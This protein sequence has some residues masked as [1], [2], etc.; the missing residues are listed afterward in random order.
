MYYLLCVQNNTRMHRHPNAQHSVAVLRAQ[1]KLKTLCNNH[2]APKIQQQHATPGET[3]ITWSRWF[4]RNT[5]LCMHCLA[6]WVWNTC[7]RWT[8]TWH[9]DLCWIV[10]R[11]LIKISPWRTKKRCFVCVR[12]LVVGYDR[13]MHCIMC[14]LPGSGSCCN[15]MSTVGL[16]QRFWLLIFFCLIPFLLLFSVDLE[17]IYQLHCEGP[18]PQVAININYC[19]LWSPWLFLSLTDYFKVNCLWVFFLLNLLWTEIPKKCKIALTR[20]NQLRAP[21]HKQWKPQSVVQNVYCFLGI[22]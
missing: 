2:R 18:E 6:S 21:T 20:Y 12:N 7:E 11:C 22:L 5:W 8:P 3:V 13:Q 17:E 15:P 10:E 4:K 16:A 19:P 14:D 1:N 9:D